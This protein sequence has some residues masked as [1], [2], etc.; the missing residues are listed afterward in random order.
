MRILQ[1]KIWKQGKRIALDEKGIKIINLSTVRT[2]GSNAA[3]DRARR[4]NTTAKVD[5][6]RIHAL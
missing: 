3:G 1:K 6:G 4:V 5:E 2:M